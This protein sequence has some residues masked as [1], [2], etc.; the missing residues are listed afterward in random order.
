MKTRWHTGAVLPRQRKDDD[1]PR[2]LI[3]GLITSRV[4]PANTLMCPRP[5]SAQDLC[6]FPSRWCAADL[7]ETRSSIRDK[8]PMHPLTDQY[9]Q[10]L[11]LV[12]TNPVHLRYKPA[13][14]KLACPAG[15]MG[16]SY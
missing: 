6:S 9:R 7:A 3:G 13:F 12:F 4:I 11:G 5:N 2:C 15:Q 10:V 14:P 1:V 16:A 8:S